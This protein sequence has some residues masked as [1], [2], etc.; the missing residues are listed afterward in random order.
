ME[1]PENK[2]NEQKS[3]ENE[4]IENIKTEE[5]CETKKL[6]VIIK[7]EDENRRL[8]EELRKETVMLKKS[9]AEN[10]D[11][12]VLT[13]SS[14]FLGAIFTYINEIW[15]IN[16]SNYTGLIYISIMAFF[17]SIIVCIISYM[18]GQKL[19]DIALK[20]GKIDYLENKT[21]DR[22][23]ENKYYS[24]NFW[25][26]TTAGIGLIVGI[27]T[28]AAF[29]FV[30]NNIDKTQETKINIGNDR[31]KSEVVT[32]EINKTTNKQG[33]KVENDKQKPAINQKQER[34]IQITNPMP[35]QEPPKK[36]NKNG[37][38]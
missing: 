7:N 9:N 21:P 20:N 1:K 25:L 33:E 18:V 3:V 36:D 16:S 31:I 2:I 12:A 6:E 24:W 26:N 15:P 4:K 10:Y 17:I 32:P 28:L 27:I 14:L 5:Y 8:Y 23:E 38:K 22:T 37:K 13:L 35:K 11:K 34:S 19:L 30:N 29:F